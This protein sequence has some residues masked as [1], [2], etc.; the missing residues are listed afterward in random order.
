M[1]EVFYISTGDVHY[2]SDTYEQALAQVVR[3]TNCND[4]DIRRA[5][6]SWPEYESVMEMEKWQ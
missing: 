4:Y 5:E 6:D 1:F 2:V 3:L